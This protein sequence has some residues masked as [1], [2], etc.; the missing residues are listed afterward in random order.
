MR[1]RQATA[2]A[3]PDTVAVVAAAGRAARMGAGVNKVFLRLAG[4]PLLG[5]VLDALRRSPEVGA[6]VVVVGAH[7]V[8][9]AE[10]VAAGSG[11]PCRVV[12][13]ADARGA[14]VLRGLEAAETFG[15]P[16]VAVHDGARP[17]LTPEL[18]RRTV[19]AARE[20]GA[21][22]AS[23]P[24]TDTIKTVDADLR[25]QVTPDRAS[26]R[27]LQTPQTF[28]LA[29]LLEAYRTL[30]ERAFALTDDCAVVEAAGGSVVLCEGEP[31]NI[32]V[33][34]PLDLAVAEAIAAGR[35]NPLRGCSEA[36][37]ERGALR[38]VGPASG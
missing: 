30:G 34:E 11:L 35:A 3:F 37:V 26:L 13:G 20:H 8:A 6:A 16:I 28:R 33:T 10:E 23:R 17:F 38:D 12:V 18:L 21:T 5:W 32:K 15:L 22:G 36:F 7:D 1:G 4:V 25:V 24:V 9:L 14:S 2:D 31:G 19:E 27:A 29:L